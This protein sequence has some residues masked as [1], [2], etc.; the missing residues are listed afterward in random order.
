LCKESSYAISHF[1]LKNLGVF[2]KLRDNLG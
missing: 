1:D 2:G